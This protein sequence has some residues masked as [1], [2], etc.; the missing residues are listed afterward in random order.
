MALG[1]FF[2]ALTR[3][4]IIAAIWT[5]VVLFMLVVLTQMGYYLALSQQSSWA[6]GIKFLS[7]LDQVRS[8]GAGM[9]DLRFI[10]L[11]LSVCAFLLYLTVKVVQARRS[12]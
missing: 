11:H 1:L 2:G 5:F 4:Q 3:N 10:A 9:L 12:S 6:E 8:F 7:V